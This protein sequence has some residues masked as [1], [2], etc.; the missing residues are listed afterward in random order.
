MTEIRRLKLYATIATALA[1]TLLVGVVA[2]LTASLTLQQ[3]LEIK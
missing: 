3:T 2:Y 1:L